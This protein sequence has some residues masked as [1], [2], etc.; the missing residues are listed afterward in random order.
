MFYTQSVH[1][2]ILF[3][4]YLEMSYVSSMGEDQMWQLGWNSCLR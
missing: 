4:M 1:W 3:E 2:K